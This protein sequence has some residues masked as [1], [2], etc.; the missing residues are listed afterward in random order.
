MLDYTKA[1]VKKTVDDFRR[2]DYLRNLVTQVVYIFYLVYALFAG[3]GYVWANAVLLGLSLAYLIFFLIVTT[4]R[5]LQAKSKTQ[6][7]VAKVFTRC[8]QLIK[9]FTLG[10][11]IYG[12]YATTTHV[13]AL[14][15]ILSALL[16]VGWILQLVFEV[17]FKFFIGRAQF[18]LEGIE[19]DYEQIT[20]PAKTVG[21]FF[22]K[23]AGKEVEPEK[24]K[25]KARLW[26]DR[27]VEETKAE[28]AEQKRAEKERKKQAK[29][30][31]K[32]TKF[33]PTPDQTTTEEELPAIEVFE[34]SP[35]LTGETEKKKRRK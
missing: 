29:T 13:T 31:E 33:Y 26:L 2:L 12:I 20:K 11:M 30:D 9:L 16:I 22:K 21:N 4:G 24:E 19:A 34:D 27:K 35:L 7:V 14:S 8:K 6:K 3:A 10:V 15:V 5:V 1:A 18:L 32:N 23:L 25:S 17:V 28:R